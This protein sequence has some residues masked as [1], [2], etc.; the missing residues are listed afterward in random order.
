[1]GVP[2]LTENR[3]SAIQHA[4][5]GAL[6]VLKIPVTGRSHSR[7]G[8]SGSS[9]ALTLRKRVGSTRRI[10][11]QLEIPGP[12]SAAAGARMARVGESTQSQNSPGLATFVAEGRKLA[13][14]MRDYLG[15]ATILRTEHF[16]LPVYEYSAARLPPDEA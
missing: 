7:V 11:R 1:M 3:W 6:W 4:L 16:F 5:C 8:A 12:L 9:P 15:T 10:S 13:K 2:Q 14:G